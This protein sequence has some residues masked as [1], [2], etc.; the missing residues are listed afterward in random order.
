MV[1]TAMSWRAV[2]KRM[3]FSIICDGMQPRVYNS[4]TETAKMTEVNNGDAHG[5]VVWDGEVQ[6]IWYNS[7]RLCS[8]LLS[9]ECR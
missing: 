3:F 6:Q 1:L 5:W 2:K 9:K 8:D 7:L 4:R